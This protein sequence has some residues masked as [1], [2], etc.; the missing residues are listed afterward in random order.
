MPPTRPRPRP[1][2]PHPKVTFGMNHQPHPASPLVLRLLEGGGPRRGSKLDPV[3]CSPTLLTSGWAQKAGGGCRSALGKGRPSWVQVTPPLKDSPETE[4]SVPAQ[5]P[6][7]G[8]AGEGRHASL[9]DRTEPLPAP[10]PAAAVSPTS[11]AHYLLGSARAPGLPPRWP[12]VLSAL[13][14]GR[15]FY[16]CFSWG[17]PAHPC[18]SRTSGARI[19]IPRERGPF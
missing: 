14:G 17:H 1:A 12:A 11:P 2:P 8:P 3:P 10:P 4:V 15:G 18:P 19:Q 5:H 6:G 16:R 9:R 7:L 13:P